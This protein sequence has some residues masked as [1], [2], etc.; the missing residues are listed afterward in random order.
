[1]ANK[2]C[3]ISLQGVTK[4]FDGNTVVDDI[5]LDI[6]KGEFVT[7][8]GPSGCGKTTT[9]RMIA[10]FESPD[11]GA[12]TVVFLGRLPEGLGMEFVEDGDLVAFDPDR[13]REGAPFRVQGN[14]S[15][16]AFHLISFRDMNPDQAAGD[17]AAL[18]DEVVLA[19]V[20]AILCRKRKGADHV[21]MVIW[22]HHAGHRR[23]AGGVDGDGA[24]LLLYVAGKSAS[25][26]AA[27]LE[28]GPEQH[29]VHA[30]TR[31]NPTV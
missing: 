9:L 23:S 17:S 12:E 21:D 4:S 22:P 16:K 26:R 1:M 6:T 11:E 5:S 31:D 24:H 7:L 30:V 14:W 27:A 13:R 18:V 8:L 20:A 15:G 19:L 25:L 29:F 28:I 10:G 3:I 2:N